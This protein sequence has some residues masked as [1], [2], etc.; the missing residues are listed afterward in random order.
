MAPVSSEHTAERIRPDFLFEPFEWAADAL[1]SII[2][3]RPNLLP[4]LISIDCKRMHLIA[5]A[6][7]HLNNEV[8][9][10]IG[11]VLIAGSA[12]A[13]LEFIP[14]P[15]PSRVE[16]VLSRYFPSSVLDLETYRQLILLLSEENASTFLQNADYVS[17]TVVSTLHG[18]PPVL[19]NSCIMNALEPISFEFG[20]SDG[21]RLL[22]SRGAAPNFDALTS[23]L[24]AI[25]DEI[26]LRSRLNRRAISSSVITT[27]S[28][29]RHVA[30][31]SLL[32]QLFSN[33][34]KES[35]SILPVPRLLASSKLVSW[36]RSSRLQQS[37]FLPHAQ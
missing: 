22:V 16:K 12:Q 24:G 7:A 13:V 35:T 18:L 20:L 26:R 10:D 17:D 1:T 4:D 19:R 37:Q 14:T 6:L 15:Y 28:A 29:C 31:I 27:S 32:V 2:I 25:T 3:A 21:L 23:E 30:M 9:P 33:K 5:L 34:N 8:T 11:E 36:N